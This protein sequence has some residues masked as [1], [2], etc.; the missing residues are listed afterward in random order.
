MVF[1]KKSYKPGNTLSAW[2]F[3]TKIL[4]QITR[5]PMDKTIARMN[6]TKNICIA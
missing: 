4:V 6:L 3:E 5:I 1:T 2:I